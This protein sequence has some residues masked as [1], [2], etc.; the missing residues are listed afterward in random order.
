MSKVAIANRGE[1]AKRIITA[2]KELNLKTVLLYA[3]GDTKQEAYRIADEKLCI[4]PADPLKS[5]LNIS[6]QIEGAKTT[7][8]QFI[9]PGYGFLS[10]NPDFAKACEENRIRFIGPSSHCLSLFG[11]KIKASQMALKAGVPVL[12]S[13]VLNFKKNSKKEF[14]LPDDLKKQTQGLTYPLMIKSASGGGGR[15]LRVAHHLEELEQLLPAVYQ[16]SIQSFNSEEIFLERY[17]PEAKH[18]EVQIFVSASGEV[19]ILGDRDCSSQR[20]HQKILEE[21]PSSLPNSLKQRIKKACLELLSLIDYQGAGTLEFLVAGN[22]FYFLE[23]NTRLQVEHTVTEMIYGIDLV[24]AQVLTALGRPP[25]LISQKDLKPRGHSIQCRLCAED[26]AQDFLP[27]G[28]E[29]LSCLW[30]SGLNTRV[31]TGFQKGDEISSF[32]DSL[33]A[34]VIVWEE[35]RTRAIEK[36]N[37]ALNQTLL[38]GFSTNLPFLKFLLLHKDFI[39]QKIFIPSLEKI[40]SEDYK[41]PPLALPEDFLKSLFQELSAKNNSQKAFNPSSKPYFNPWSDFLA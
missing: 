8:A 4:G 5:Y 13:R 10:E 30:P 1:I 40:H 32:Y 9:H 29:I 20:R 2:C 17:L 27:T 19:F 12:S 22:D 35:N 38:F 39:S 34:K 26:P 14:V 11:N 15:G 28:G 7:G 33:I 23:M 24:K 6:A 18:I 31:E 3:S 36:M 37:Q 21:A 41:N 25:F 16:E